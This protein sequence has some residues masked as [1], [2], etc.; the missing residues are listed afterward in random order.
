LINAL[1]KNAKADEMKLE[2]DLN[3]RTAQPDHQSFVL[4]KVAQ[5]T[6]STDERSPLMILGDVPP[7]PSQLV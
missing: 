4:A 6:C 5:Q 3:K 1:T 2:K 7:S